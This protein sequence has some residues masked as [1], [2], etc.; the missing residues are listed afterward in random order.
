[1]SRIHV[2]YHLT[3]SK[4]FDDVDAIVS[5]LHSNE[6][7]NIKKPLSNCLVFEKNIDTIEVNNFLDYAKRILS[8]IYGL[9]FVLSMVQID[10]N[11]TRIT[12]N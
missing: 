3:I 4:N 1:M 6:F 12:L 10:N 11:G 8:S 9:K 5:K 7:V 2:V